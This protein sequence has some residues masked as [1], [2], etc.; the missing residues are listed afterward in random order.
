MAK[1][2][3]KAKTARTSKK[4]TRPR[5]TG[6]TATPR[7]TARKVLM[8][9]G[10]KYHLVEKAAEQME[11]MLRDETPGTWDLTVSQDP[12]ALAQLATGKFAAVILHTTGFRDAL[13]E[14]L[15]KA[16]VGFVKGGGALVG[17]HSAADSFRDSRPYIEMLNA[18]F[19]THPRFQRWPVTIVD[20]DHLMTVRMP[21]FDVDDELYVLQSH[22]PKRSHILA[23]TVYQ[24]E[25]RP[26]AF[27]HTYGKGRVAYVAL[28]HNLKA[29]THREF[30]KLVTRGLRWT[31]GEDLDDGREIRCGIVGYGPSYNMGLRHGEWINAQRGMRTVA[32]CDTLADRRDAAEAELPDVRTF[33]SLEAMLKMRGLDLVVNILPHNLHADPSLQCLK[34]G[35]HVVLEKPFCLTTEEATAMI[36][37]ANRSEAMLSC[38]HNRRWDGDYQAL[39]DIV[40]RGLVGDVF[41]VEAYMGG[42]R[43]PG[44]A[45]RSDKAVS[46]GAMYDWGAHFTDWILRLVNKPV[47]QVTGLF[48]KRWWQH[49]TN[50]DQ[51]Q[52][53]LRFEGGEMADLQISSLAAVEK[54]RWRV[55]GTQG[56]LVSDPPEAYRV[57]SHT[58][59]V[60]VDGRVRY[61]PMHSGA[62]YYRD[63]ADHLLMGE[64]LEVTAEQA[65]E[66]IAV[67]ETAER[68]S[69][70]GR[71]LPLPRE[72]Y[73]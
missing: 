31:V 66:V 39:R 24:G 52:A 32:V 54:P 57:V 35:K 40:A 51:T 65:R 63:V 28:G 60:A 11:I 17:I 29:W 18:E 5:A 46:G 8:L 13:D 34:A 64:P 72:V 47:A 41:H 20:R 59:G 30:R 38:F 37:A 71:S 19:Q 45:W 7:R 3:K 4:T 69:T 50:E 67:I 27:T 21:D 36:K 58:S 62:P 15:E 22:D 12:Q 10:G 56:G 68:S 44:F 1:K 23:E 70:E 43:R 26:L 25:R 49:V 2:A 16:L 61:A 73:E 55:L 33:A 48:H 14:S 6:R 53:V 9:V 42:Y